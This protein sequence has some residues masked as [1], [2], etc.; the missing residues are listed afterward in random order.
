MIFHTKFI[1]LAFTRSNLYDYSYI[2]IR[3]Q[4]S[5]QNLI[6]MLDRKEKFNEA[7]FDILERMNVMATAK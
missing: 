7:L 1:I 4:G 5:N 2:I 3:N 6:A